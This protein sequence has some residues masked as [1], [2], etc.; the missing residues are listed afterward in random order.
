[1]QPN[2]IA[3]QALLLVIFIL[4]LGLP[5]VAELGNPIT[6]NAAD[7]PKTALPT[8]KSPTDSW[9]RFN[10][11]S[12]GEDLEAVDCDQSFY[13]MAV[14][15]NGAIIRSSNLGSDWMNFPEVT[16][17]NLRG[18]DCPIAILCF[19]VGEGGTILK[20]DG[21]QNKWFT[22]ASGTNSNLNGISCASFSLCYAVG[23]GGLVLRSANAGGTWQPAT[24]ANT[25]TLNAIEC[26]N[27]LTCYAVGNA[28]TIR[29]TTDGGTTWNP[30]TTIEN[31]NL[32]DISCP[33]V[34]TCIA[35]TSS[36]NLIK[37]T[38]GSTTWSSFE[39]RGGFV[40][41]GVGCIAETDCVTV[42]STRLLRSNANDPNAMWTIIH[43]VEVG[44]EV[45]LSAVSC[46]KLTNVINCVAVGEN[47]LVIRTNGNFP[48]TASGYNQ[49][50]ADIECISNT[51][52]LAVGKR[53]TL[54]R[55]SNGG[56]T[57]E[58]ITNNIAEFHNFQALDCTKTGKCAAVIHQG[59][60]YYSNDRGVTWNYIEFQ[61][62]Y[63]PYDI[64]CVTDNN[65]DTC[66]M[67]YYY[68]TFTAYYSA[69]FDFATQIWSA[70]ITTGG[71]LNSLSCYGVTGCIA[72]GANGTIISITQGSINW[73]TM[74][75]PTTKDLLDV[76]CLTY[77]DCYAVGAN[78]TWLRYKYNEGWKTYNIG[79]DVT[80][81]SIHCSGVNACT[82]LAANGEI[83]HIIYDQPMFYAATG[84]ESGL[85][86][87]NCQFQCLVVGDG[88]TI[89]TNQF[90][91]SNP[92]E[93]TT[94]SLPGTLSWVNEI[95]PDGY[96][97][98]VRLI[99]SPVKL[100]TN[101]PSKLSLK[102]G[103]QILGNCGINGG[104]TVID[105]NNNPGLVL[106]GG[107]TALTGLKLI[108]AKGPAI[109]NTPGA[110]KN[111]LSCVKIN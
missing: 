65:K 35:T 98:K 27:G 51:E 82:V 13:C 93:N 109:T 63:Q 23:D 18:V 66:T 16:K 58:K 14:G 88:G 92:T 50:L 3:K 42:S 24:L 105:L 79:K 90:I 37:T 75:S 89:I 76:D 38:G 34:N 70:G 47:G 56:Q 22:L 87:F 73:D 74:T 101:A 57:W 85:N 71:I 69:T 39:A 106:N 103:L 96:Q 33:A 80:L 32:L 110:G 53:G 21:N 68:S 111:I 77:Y 55:T 95:V 91:V 9:Y 104:A 52:C 78:G 44:D 62:G 10:P 45:N 19:V 86:D 48:T 107:G 99:T 11:T 43:E 29:V 31:T 108:N 100:I 81:K 5:L 59:K 41:K 8:K 6:T 1:M 4:G 28:G 97:P 94:A 25:P 20:Y 67:L 54:L 60:A 12:T 102:P 7:T 36:K 72:V 84:I 49:D 83:F 15:A 30:H 2:R 64:S 46:I 17:A 26:T 40:S 61:G